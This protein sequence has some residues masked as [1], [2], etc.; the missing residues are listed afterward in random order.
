[1]MNKID[2]RRYIPGKIF[3]EYKQY[4]PLLEQKK[5]DHEKYSEIFFMMHKI[6][7]VA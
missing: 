1:M 3:V 5:C 6:Y 7:V 4:N 2:V